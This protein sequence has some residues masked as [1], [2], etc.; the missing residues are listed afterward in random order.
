[1]NVKQPS[2][3]AMVVLILVVMGII[4]T[5]ATAGDAKA[6]KLLELAKVHFAN[7]LTEAEKAL[8]QHV[9]IGESI[10]SPQI[11]AGTVINGITVPI[12]EDVTNLGIDILSRNWPRSFLIRADR[13]AWLCCDPEASSQVTSLGIEIYGDFRIDGDLTIPFAKTSFPLIIKSCTITGNLILSG[14]SL[15]ALVLDGS[16]VKSLQADNC[17]FGNGV[18][19]RDGFTADGEVRFA[20]AIVSGDFNCGNSHF[21]NPNGYSIFAKGIVINGD[22][23]FNG[24]FRAEGQVFLVGATIGGDFSCDGG[25][26]ESKIGEKI[27]LCAENIKIGGNAYLTGTTCRGLVLLARCR[28]DGMLDC[29]AGS[30][31]NSNA[32]ALMAEGA[33]VK[34]G[35]FLRKKFL[36]IGS[37]DFAAS[38]VENNLECV[39]AQFLSSGTNIAVNFGLLKCDRSVAFGECRIIGAA[40][41]GG[42]SIEGCFIFDRMQDPTNIY[43]DLRGASMNTLV[44]NAESWPAPGK[45]FLDGLVYSR[46][47]ADCRLDAESRINWL[48]LQPRDQ[49]L[50]QPYEQLA[51]VLRQMGHEEAAAQIM[52]AKGDDYSDR[53]HFSLTRL[54]YLLIG[55]FSGYGYLPVRAF[56]WSLGFIFV[57][58]IVFNRGY[59]SRSLL[60]SGVKS[61]KNGHP[62]FDR[63][64]NFNPFIYSLET[65]VPL[66]EL[67]LAKRWEPSSR[68]LRNYLYFH[69]IAGWVLTTLW[70][71]GF[72]GIVKG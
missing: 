34:G 26:F 43:L 65:F 11:P 57:G 41:L 22:A 50:P 39:S 30:F 28:I 62:D 36:S 38:T 47:S 15:G 55:C 12:D 59:R 67:D 27:A 69:R 44:D 68:A 7:D 8:F 71:G 1:M 23:F 35:L 64:A 13:I 60:I 46:L 49:F 56:Y 20:G 6:T 70:I 5:R 45:L 2:L 9:S 53:L 63:E 40:N 21:Y 19:L 61:K 48:H 72:T 42:A 54:W 32:V 31:I 17:I 51:S 66:L 14:C 16:H 37:V 33:D 10:G 29:E 18:S 58:G 25:R 24:D 52:V 3:S 4:A